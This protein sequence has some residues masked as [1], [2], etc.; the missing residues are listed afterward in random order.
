[1]IVNQE[2]VKMVG[3]NTL[4]KGIP[5]EFLKNNIKPKNYFGVKEGTIIYTKGDESTELYLI[6]E[7]E[8]KIKFC[9][10]NKVEYRFIT[11]FFGENEL[12]N[13]DKRASHAVAN[14][15]SILY[16]INSEELHNLIQQQSKISE[17][18]NKKN[19]NEDL[20]NLPEKVD[21]ENS[22]SEDSNLI[23]DENLTLNDD[24][25]CEENFENA[26]DEDLGS[27]T[28]KQESNERLPK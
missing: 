4:F 6:V 26:S 28:K 2:L 12:L 20:Y 3:S 10:K 21:T 23:P 7:G 24:F 22:E 16:A 14:H 8:V 13:K 27:S 17:N 15:D 5:K 25:N 1:M 18:L 11:D 19:D 9:E